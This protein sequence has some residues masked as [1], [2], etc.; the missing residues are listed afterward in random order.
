MI[1]EIVVGVLFF[2]WGIIIL[3]GKVDKWLI[4]PIKQINTK[5][6]RVVKGVSNLLLG[7][8]FATLQLVDGFVTCLLGI[9]I[10]VAFILHLTWCRKNPDN[11]SSAKL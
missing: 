10:I 3:L 9:L 2:V 7:V 4:Y 1:I 11:F 6:F 5:R 8:G